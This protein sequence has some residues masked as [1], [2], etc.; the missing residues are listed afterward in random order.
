M[1]V[2]QPEPLHIRTKATDRLTRT[3]FQKLGLQNYLATASVAIIVTFSLFWL[4]FRF[5]GEQ[6]TI[7]FSDSMYAV[8]AWIGAFW[9]CATAFRARYGPLQLEPRHQLAWLLIG[10]ALFSNGVGGAY[11]TYLE[12]VGQLNPVP[13]IADIGFTLFYCLTFIGLLL[14]PTEPGSERFRIRIAL[15]ALITTLC[16]LGVSWY[17]VIGPVFATEK[18]IPKL[19]VAISYP[20]WDILL[21]LAIVLLIYQRTERILH[22][23]LLLC[24]V[25]ILA[26]IC[27]DTGYAIT[28]PPNTYVTGT[29]YIDTFWFIGFLLI[30]LSGLYQYAT[31]ARKVFHER[32][33]QSRAATGEVTEYTTSERVGNR[34]P[35]RRLAFFQSFLIYFPL[36][37]LLTLMLYS[38]IVQDEKRSFFLV[39][40]TAVVGILVAVR[41]LLTT[42]ENEILLRERE[43]RRE[44]AEHLRILSAKLTEVLEFD[45]LLTR[46]VSIVA[47]ELGFDG[48]LLLLSEDLDRPFDTQTDLLIRAV[49]STSPQT[50][51]WRLP[52]RSFPLYANLLVKEV[53]ILWTRQ[54]LA[55]PEELHTWL[56]TQQ[57]LS[58]LFIPLSYQG[59]IL[60]SLGFCS[61]TTE[62]FSAHDSYMATAF[63]EQAAIAIEHAHLY[64]A[65]QE[66]ELF[67]QALA[68]IAARLNTAIALELGIG[69]DIH[70]LICTESANALQADYSLLYV[71]DS[72]S[73]L[74]PL[75]IYTSDQEPAS[76]LNEWPTIRPNEYEAHALSSLQPI[77]AH[78]DTSTT[79]DKLSTVGEKIATLHS[80][81][82]VA[83]EQ[84]VRTPIGG[85]R[86]R[87]VSS[88]REALLRRYVHTAILAPLITRDTPVG[89]L[90]LARSL[91]PGS[92]DKK[93]FALAD[94]PQAQDFAEQAAVAFTNA[95][96]YSQLRNAHQRLQELDELKDQFMITASHE[97]R[98]PLTAVQ[99]YLELLA[100][101]GDSLPHDQRQEFLQKARR[102]CDE[103]V[104]LLSN[105]MD[106]SRLEVEAGI[107][108]AYLESVS[109]QDIIKN[110]IDL[111]EPHLTQEQREVHVYIPPH[112]FV[113]ADPTRLRQV[114]LNISVN[115]LKYSPP[116]T[117]ITFSARGIYDHM[118]CA[119]I[120]VTD[121]GKGI[122]PQDQ[123]QLFQ[124]FVRLESDLNSSV[125]GSG[126]GL[127]ISRRLIEAMGGKIWIE[128]T[129]IAG[130][131][132]T[133]HIQLPLA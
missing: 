35:S 89:L 41:Y 95:Q 121:R 46:I 61:R 70:Q 104:L 6:K 18:Q 99:G 98:T 25:G 129:G 83:A 14:M 27:A 76:M 47:Y 73:N 72:N 2:R 15:D 71:I 21:I 122:K 97:L 132:S 108:P 93:S 127:Y 103:L 92:Q 100:E 29:F 38:E 120:S 48:A 80:Q 74:V 56:Q 44:E 87:R 55:L 53:N 1:A 52:G 11:Y 10:L 23:S 107:R 37:V 69:A 109:V 33:Q 64:Q 77:L 58:T 5:G 75:A 42:H 63:T 39:L 31:I 9:A 96:L 32:E 36:T 50:I 24:G 13:S 51:T 81:Q 85:L 112:L 86:G 34:I 57:M 90:V 20:F 111:I 115:A 16:V 106:V 22:S 78:I 60:G 117:P 126:L 79:T 113:Q 4:I 128:S 68:N 110:A 65:A 12:Q 59:K 82:S 19:L 130:A 40:L 17:F 30:G 91:R 105:V 133:F 45:P 28:I 125:R 26:Q 114:L 123:A 116:G 102:G 8:A 84:T 54:S 7:F 43:Q 119:V 124:R 101:Y 66:H 131:G 49:T 118:P 67:S 3:Y 62:L 94:L 88:L